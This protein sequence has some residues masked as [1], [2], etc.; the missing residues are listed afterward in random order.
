MKKLHYIIIIIFIIYGCKSTPLK[1]ISSPNTITPL[2]QAIVVNDFSEYIDSM[3]IV[4]L[5]ATPE[6]FITYIKKILITKNKDIIILNSTGILVFD[7]YG[8]FL[9]KI[10]SRG[11][12]PEEYVALRDICL[13]NDYQQILALD[14]TNQIITY[15]LDDGKFIKRTI[16]KM[17]DPDKQ[18]LDFLEICPSNNN[19]F[20][21]FCC[22]PP[23]I[24]DFSQDFFCLIE[25]DKDG[26]F[27]NKFLQRIDFIF[28]SYLIS[29]S[30][31]NE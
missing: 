12:G 13:S 30:Y 22:N 27:K 14:C 15:N 20:F 6:S 25:F 8:K 5:E 3:A 4:H 16:I 11:R 18:Y 21:L 9:R 7:H 23:D 28:P 1:V 31:N 2:E 19:G 17:N 29:Q 10:G 26:E 24:C